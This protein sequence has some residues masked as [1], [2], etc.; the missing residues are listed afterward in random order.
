MI[1]KAK[2]LLIQHLLTNFTLFGIEKLQN[3]MQWV[4]L[5]DRAVSILQSILA[6]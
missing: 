3:Q 1:T 2:I 6:F 4:E 5:I